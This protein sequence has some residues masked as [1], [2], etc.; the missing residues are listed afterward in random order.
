MCQFYFN[1][2]YA[3]LTNRRQLFWQVARIFFYLSTV[4]LQY[5]APIVLLLFLSLSWLSVGKFYKLLLNLGI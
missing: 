5:L 2:A 4:A 1:F 3:A